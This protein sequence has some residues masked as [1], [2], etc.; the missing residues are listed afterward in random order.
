MLTTEETKRIAAIM[1][2]GS[3]KTKTKAEHIVRQL[4]M[5]PDAVRV[6]FDAVKAH[7]YDLIKNEQ[8]KE[9]LRN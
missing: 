4:L 5:I 1:L 6:D 7:L 8:R 2:S 3:P 9:K